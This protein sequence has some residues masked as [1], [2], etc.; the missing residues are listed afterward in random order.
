MINKF[1][2]PIANQNKRVK[3]VNKKFILS[4][5]PNPI[6]TGISTNYS[7]LEPIKSLI[8]SL[9]NDFKKVTE[10]RDNKLI[11]ILRERDSKL[12][13]A[14]GEKMKSVLKELKNEKN[15]NI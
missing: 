11:E 15:E 13:E 14:F 9:F 2:N 10:E 5:K 8:E 12:V 7:K 6:K 3:Q 4:K 1:E